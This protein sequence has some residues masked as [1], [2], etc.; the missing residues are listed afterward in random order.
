MNACFSCDNRVGTRHTLAAFFLNSP[1][2]FD[3]MIFTCGM[4]SVAVFLRFGESVQGRE[5]G[6]QALP[7]ATFAMEYQRF[8]I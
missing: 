2:G 5:T 1:Y 7:T 8:Q 6:S 3:A 4:A